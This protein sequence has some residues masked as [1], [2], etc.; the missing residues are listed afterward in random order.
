MEEPRKN[1][2][3]SEGNTARDSWANWFRG[4]GRSNRFVL[5]TWERRPSRGSMVGAIVCLSLLFLIIAVVSVRFNGNNDKWDDW[6]APGE[7]RTGY[8]SSVFCNS[9]T[10]ENPSLTSSASVYLLRNEPKLTAL[11]NF[12]IADSL[13]LG[14]RYYQYWNFY[15]YPGSNY[16][17]SSYLSSGTVNYYLIKG[18]TNFQNWH[19]TD[20][21][22]L[23]SVS[24]SSMS[25]KTL[26]RSFTVEDEYYFVLYN[27]Y[28]T[29]AKVKVTLAFNR[30]EYSA[31]SGG[32]VTSC[33]AAPSSKC[34]M[35]IPYN[36]DYVVLI[37]AGAPG[38]GDW[39]TTVDIDTS[40]NPRVWVYV[41]I[42]LLPTLGVIALIVCIAAACYCVKRRMRYAPLL[43]VT[44]QEVVVEDPETTLPPNPPPYT[45]EEVT[46]PSYKPNPP[47]YTP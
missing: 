29:D 24:Y 31:H 6:Y 20:G 40:C 23:D 30:T 22:S 42:V 39:G 5:V 45:P 41:M 10:L 2:R 34:T 21:Y 7:T 43:S 47:A 44:M 25:N 36:S 8:H 3:M 11:Y 18:K 15:M 13:V 9:V 28:Q 1:Q 14:S 33:T 27:P 16:T 32:V 4:I 26:S 37:E 17:F 46:L 19:R 35:D 12:T 38:D